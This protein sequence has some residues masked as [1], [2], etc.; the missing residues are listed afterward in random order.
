M[1]G[2]KRTAR[3]I[4]D[5]EKIEHERIKGTPDHDRAFFVREVDSGQV[6]YIDDQI[7]IRCAVDT[8][9][10]GPRVRDAYW[11]WRGQSGHHTALNALQAVSLYIQEQASEKAKK[12]DMKNLLHWQHVC[13]VA[14]T[15]KTK[16]RVKKYLVE[17]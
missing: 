6:H 14:K 12:L 7:F 4:V 8:M 1:P 16:A 10:L 15:D 17:E 3:E 13:D 5:L 2:R 11:R 9:E